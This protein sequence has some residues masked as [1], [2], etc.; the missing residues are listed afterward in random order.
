MEIACSLEQGSDTL[1]SARC[2]GRPCRNSRCQ[3]RERLWAAPDGI[4]PSEES[5]SES[6]AVGAVVSRP[7]R[8]QIGG[9]SVDQRMVAVSDRYGYN[10]LRR[11]VPI[12]SPHATG[13]EICRLTWWRSILSQRLGP[14][15][16]MRLCAVKAV[17]V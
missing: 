1:F 9:A 14:T 10:S 8:T 13:P 17:C 6:T 4:A 7:E 2:P 3:R 16:P 5:P 11:V 15:S 12:M